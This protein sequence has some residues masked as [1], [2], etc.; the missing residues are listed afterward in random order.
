MGILR[1]AGAA[2]KGRC[3]ESGDVARDAAA[4]SQ[5]RAAAI[6]AV[7]EELVVERAH[8][9]QCLVLLAIGDGADEGP[10]ARVVQCCFDLRGVQRPD[11]GIGD[12]SDGGALRCPSRSQ[13]V[14]EVRQQAVADVDVVAAAG[15]FH[16]Q[17][18][19]VRQRDDLRDDVVHVQP[20]RLD[21]PGHCAVGIT[22][23]GQ[24]FRDTRSRIGHVEQRAVVVVAD[25]PQNLVGAGVQAD[26][27]ARALHRGAIGRIHQRAAAGRHDEARLCAQI[28][29]HIGLDLPER[30]FAVLRKDARDRFAR[31][32]Y[33]LVV[34]IDKRPA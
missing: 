24:Q 7:V 2:H 25:A 1:E 9:V 30:G 29:A 5:H 4:Q 14:A 12:D 28:G 8:R 10:V 20:R 27:D 26:D 33:D 15:M 16:R 11:D 13:R 6:E 19:G 21:V 34:H 22:A 3:C 23:R 32:R 31:P 17:R 18:D